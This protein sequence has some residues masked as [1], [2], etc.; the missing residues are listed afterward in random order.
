[1][2]STSLGR[3]TCHLSSFAFVVEGGGICTLPA[4]HHGEPAVK[5]EVAGAQRTMQR[6][7][8]NSSFFKV[9]EMLL[10]GHQNKGI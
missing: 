9:L 6:P 2:P 7:R 1:M 3:E 8:G 4:I 10:S 5:D